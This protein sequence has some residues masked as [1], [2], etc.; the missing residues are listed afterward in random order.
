[1]EA[2][3]PSPPEETFDEVHRRVSAEH[4]I[5]KE[6]LAI[7]DEAARLVLETNGDDQA[8][9]ALRGALWNVYNRFVD[10]LAMEESH[11]APLLRDLDSWGPYRV[12]NMLEEHREQRTVIDALI[13]ECAGGTK[14]DVELADDTRWFVATITKDIEGEEVGLDAIEHSDEDVDICGE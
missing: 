10:H 5:I 9:L 8:A 7:L 4:A 11:L 14:S 3:A 6:E 13:D 1:M 2:A 12:E